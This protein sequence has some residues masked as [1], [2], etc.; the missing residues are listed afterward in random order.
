MRLPDIVGHEWVLERFRR[1][2]QQ[3]R[4]ASTFLFVGPPGIG[5]RTTA[6][7]IAQCLLCETTPP[8]QLASCQS[9]PSCRQVAA[10]SHPDLIMIRKPDDKNFI[11]VELFIGAREH[12]MR[13]GLCHDIALKPFRGGRKIAIIDDADY[14]NPE[15]ANCLLKTLEE[16]PGNALIILIG[17]SQQRQLPTIR[18]RCQIVRFASLSVEQVAQLL[19]AHQTLE[20]TQIDA[21]AR[22]SGGSLSRAL[23]VAD[24]ALEDARRGLVEQLSQH[25]FDAVAVAKELADFVEAAGKDATPRRARLRQMV[26]A[27]VDFY[28]HLMR[29]AAG[30]GAEGDA[31]SPE[32]VVRACGHWDRRATAVAVCLDRCL[33]ALTQ[34]DANANLQTLIPCWLDDLAQATLRGT[35]PK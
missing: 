3:G 14:L 17:T 26:L 31:V 34:I 32:L 24:S 5:K 4:L 11:P 27:A 19:Q 30:A 21:A 29:H 16:P 20:G 6:L 18:S 22:T 23:E 2:L 10:A 25:D 15:G 33:D 12:R 8:D 9:C 28:R 35:R 13:E 7:H 1:N